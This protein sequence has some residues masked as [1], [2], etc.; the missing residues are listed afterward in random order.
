MKKYGSL[1]ALLVVV[2]LAILVVTTRQKTVDTV[3]APHSIAKVEKLNRIELTQA[4][5]DGGLV[6]F[7]FGDDGWSL[8][9]PVAAPLADRVSDKIAGV[10]SKKISTDD[11]KLDTSKLED[12]GLGEEG[13]AKVSL[14]AE[15]AEVPA[16]EFWF[17]KTFSV[18][19]TGAKRTF[20]K[21]TDGKVFRAQTELGD[22]LGKPLDQ[23]RSKVVQKFDRATVDSIRVNYQNE[24]KNIEV[25][26]EDEDWKLKS[27]VVEFELERNATSGLLNSASNL[28]AT[29]FADGKKPSEVG[30]DPWFVNVI[31]RD[32]G[33]EHHRL[34]M[35]EPKDGKAYVM[36]ENGTD[37]FEIAEQTARQFAASPLTLRKRLVKDI[38]ADDVTRVDF[39]GE[40]KISVTKSDD[41]WKFARGAKGKVKESALTPKLQAIAQLRAIRFEEPTLTEAGLARPADK[42]VLTTKAGKHTLLIGGEADKKGNLWAKWSDVDLV[43]VVPQWVKSRGGPTPAELIEEGS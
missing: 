30:L 34:L 41:G 29:G 15:G 1:I 33:G 35:S 21:T 2:V 40:A 16:A 36:V 24:A 23:L 19:G 3:K 38:N 31:A 28:I 9:K 7:E 18:K 20:I 12:F 13:A 5:K 11:I 4:G 27:P 42:V 10:F 14:F 39:G 8:K 26:K 37:I 22:V 6:V 25:V 32:K 17:G 43:M